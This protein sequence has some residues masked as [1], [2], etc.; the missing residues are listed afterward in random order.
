[1]LPVLRTKESVDRLAVLVSG[2]AIMKILGVPQISS[3]IGEAQVA[4]CVE[5]QAAAAFYPRL[6]F[7]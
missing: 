1:M 6:E 3:S 4:A 7:N 5:A 2:E